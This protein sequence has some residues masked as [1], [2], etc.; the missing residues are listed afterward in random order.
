MLPVEII[1]PIHPQR[2]RAILCIVL[3]DSYWQPKGKSRHQGL[4]RFTPVSCAAAITTNSTNIHLDPSFRC[5]DFT[6]V[7]CYW[8]TQI[9]ICTKSVISK[10]RT[11]TFRV[12]NDKWRSSMVCKKINHAYMNTVRC[13]NAPLKQFADDATLLFIIGIDVFLQGPLDNRDACMGQWTAHT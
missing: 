3:E 11:T 6:Y 4:H 10:A 5:T 12:P 8:L 1:I 2:T 9:Q 13:G 7:G